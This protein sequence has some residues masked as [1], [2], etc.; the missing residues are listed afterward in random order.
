MHINHYLRVILLHEALTSYSTTNEPLA[1]LDFRDVG[2]P[3]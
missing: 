3:R 2:F 1:F